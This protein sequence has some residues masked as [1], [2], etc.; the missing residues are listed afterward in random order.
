VLRNLEE[1]ATEGNVVPV[2]RPVGYYV[3]AICEEPLSRLLAGWHWR[4]IVSNPLF[5]VGELWHVL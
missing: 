4:S 3:E 1:S 2:V 5:S